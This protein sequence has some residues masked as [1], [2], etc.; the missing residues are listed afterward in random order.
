MLHNHAYKMWVSLKSTSTKDNRRGFTIVE[1]LIVIVVIGILA[2]ITIVAYN[3][4][5]QR[6]RNSQV[7]AGVNAY[8]KALMSYS[9]INSTYPANSGCLGDN[10]PSNQ[11]W[12]GV[13]GTFSTD[14][15]LDANIATV[16]NAKPTL[17][18]S[19]MSIGIANDMRAGALYRTAPARIV[20]YLAGPGQP[21]GV[22]GATGVTEGSVVTQCLLTLP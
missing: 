12:T 3:G 13:D 22:S 18:T 16:I 20:Y 11:C 9:T 15:T 21:C 7:V 8:A 19:L 4:I 2:A 5:Q 10:Y 1:L 17:A 14:A 6:A